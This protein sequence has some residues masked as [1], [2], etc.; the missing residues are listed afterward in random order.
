MDAIVVGSLV[1]RKCRGTGIH[2]ECSE[3]QLVNVNMRA[4]AILILNRQMSALC[5]LI[6]SYHSKKYLNYY[7]NVYL[8]NNED[9]KETS[10]SGTRSLRPPPQ[11][12]RPAT[13]VTPAFFFILLQYA[14]LRLSLSLVAK[15]VGSYTTTQ[16]NVCYI[17]KQRNKSSLQHII[18]LK[19]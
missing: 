1:K 3:T 7:K 9:V 17:F 14:K 16:F 13:L 4:E 8:T 5:I 12:L 10:H 15:Q 6:H 19:N 18:H 11:S 2:A